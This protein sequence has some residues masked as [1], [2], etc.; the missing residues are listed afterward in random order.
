ML[1]LRSPRLRRSLRKAHFAPAGPATNIAGA[2][3]GVVVAV[4]HAAYRAQNG[5]EGG[6]N[7]TGILSYYRSW[8]I[9]WWG[10]GERVKG[11]IQR[12]RVIGKRKNVA[13]GKEAGGSQG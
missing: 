11:F 8:N 1:C 4:Q 13:N 12:S 5:A 7:R 10:I 2:C 6:E 9:V 3:E